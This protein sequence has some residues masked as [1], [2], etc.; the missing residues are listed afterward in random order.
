MA[1]I[2]RRATDV[3]DLHV[4]TTER[5]KSGIFFFNRSFKK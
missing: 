4:R 5:R 3:G 1:E 2:K